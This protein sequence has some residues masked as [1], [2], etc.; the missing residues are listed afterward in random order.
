MQVTDDCLAVARGV[1]GSRTA[2]L[3]ALWGV[4]AGARWDG[5]G[6]VVGCEEGFKVGEELWGWGRWCCHCEGMMLIVLEMTENC[7]CYLYTF[8]LV[9][10]CPVGLAM[11][12]TIIHVRSV[13]AE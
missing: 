9:P 11:L 8:L 10:E 6:L 1:G 3:H 13:G 7:E 5:G 2:D 4:E 12:L